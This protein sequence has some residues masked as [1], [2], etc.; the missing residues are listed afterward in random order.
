LTSRWGKLEAHFFCTFTTPPLH[1]PPSSAHP[2]PRNRSRTRSRGP[3]SAPPPALL[4]FPPQP[5][6]AVSAHAAAAKKGTKTLST[7]RPRVYRDWEY[8]S[9]RA[10]QSS[11]SGHVK[12]P[13]DCLP[14]PP[15]HKTPERCCSRSLHRCKGKSNDRHLAARSSPSV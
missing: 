4:H 1:H 15:A 12:E 14:R 3:A 9:N 6:L 5:D 13:T 2:N 10:Q 8:R 11:Q 7:R